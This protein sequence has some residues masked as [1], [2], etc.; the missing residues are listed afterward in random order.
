MVWMREPS[1]CRSISAQRQSLELAAS[2]YGTFHDSSGNPLQ[3]GNTYR[4]HVPAEV[5][6]RE[7]W[8]I[9]V[10]SLE[11]SSFF[12]NSMRLTLGSL[13]K[14]LHK[15]PDGSVDIYFG[16]KP[17]A[18]RSPTGFTPSPARNGSRGSACMA[19]RRQFSTRVG[20][21]RTSSW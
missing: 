4:L 14:G 6:V 2:T 21:C 9:T 10:Y 17:P 19:R 3:G 7:F 5:P 12:L 15:N 16:P 1:L 11:T 20:S 18:G 8:S 13:D